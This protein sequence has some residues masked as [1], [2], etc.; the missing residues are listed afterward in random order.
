LKDI[1]LDPRIVLD[2]IEEHF[3][4]ESDDPLQASI[5]AKERITRLPDCG[6][7]SVLED[8]GVEALKKVLARICSAGQR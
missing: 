8:G 7:W 4:A 3:L 5:L 1:A 6:H 2:G